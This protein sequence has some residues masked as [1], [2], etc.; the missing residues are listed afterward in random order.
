MPAGVTN[1]HAQALPTL[2]NK[3]S[4]TR[5]RAWLDNESSVDVAPER[6]YYKYFAEPKPACSFRPDS[7]PV[8]RSDG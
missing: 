6:L 1:L 7:F 4:H 5:S 3:L 8:E 2:T